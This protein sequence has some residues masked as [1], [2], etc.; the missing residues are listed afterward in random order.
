MY[1]IILAASFVSIVLSC[2]DTGNKQVDTVTDTIQKTDESGNG[3]LDAIPPVTDSSFALTT[4]E[5]EDDS[6][7][8]NGSMPTSWAAAGIDDPVAFK[9]F[10]KHLQYWVA[11]DKRDSVAAVIAYPMK[12][13][14]V[15]N[16]QQF[17]AGY[18]MYM[19]KGVKN[20]LKEQNYRQIFRRDQGAMIGS[21][22]LWLAQTPQGFR[23]T[24]I[25]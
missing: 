18:D 9:K 3:R 7:F 6:V 16:K 8:A 14:A 1:K 5:M 23:I 13:P 19:N 11:H 21:G 2:N 24:A 4:A 15:K 17:L 22:Q 25:N 10:L 20:A 12:H